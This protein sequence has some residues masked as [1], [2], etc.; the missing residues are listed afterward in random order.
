MSDQDRTTLDRYLLGQLPSDEADRIE[1]RLLAETGLF[2]L[3]ESVEDEIIDRYSRGELSPEERRRFERRLLSSERIGERVTFARALAAHG[4]RGEALASPAPGSFGREAAVVALFRPAG[5]R[6]A[7]AAT[8]L[9]ALLGAWLA[10]QVVRLE[11]RA[12][13]LD[14]ARIAAVELA[15]SATA[16]AREAGSTAE[17]AR[18]REAKA[19]ELERELAEAR[20]KLAELETAEPPDGA[21][22]GE[23]RVRRPGDYGGESVTASLFLAL[24]TRSETGPETLRLEGANQAELQLELAGPRPSKAIAATVSRGGQVIWHEEGI[25]VRSLGR[26]LTAVLT[27]PEESLQVGRYRVELTTAGSAAKELLGTYE[28]AVDR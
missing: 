23:R 20:V 13:E 19:T 6:L 21:G 26:E 27:L 5:A 9:I 8:L 10:L 28:L 1:A 25:E 24:A 22:Q 3:A 4:R 2:E 11:E 15:E 17:S 12:E 16:R 7:W 18:R 14:A